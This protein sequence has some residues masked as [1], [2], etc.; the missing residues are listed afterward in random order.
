MNKYFKVK[1]SLKNCKG[2]IKI[3]MWERH[4]KHIQ[5]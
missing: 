3:R 1:L 2:L 5:H 4:K